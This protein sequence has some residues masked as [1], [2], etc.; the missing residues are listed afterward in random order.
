MKICDVVKNSVWYDPRVK[1]QLDS[2]V[3]S[4]IEV[5]AV[6]IEDPRAD[7]SEISK[8]PCRVA[9][10]KIDNKYYSSKRSFLKK[11][12][13]ELVGNKG[14]FKHL[15]NEKPDV[16]HAN[17]LNALIPAYKAAKKLKCKLIYDTHEIFLENPWIANNKLVRAVWAH[18]EKK[19][20]KR[21]DLVVCV[22]HA[23]ADYLAKEYNIPKPMVITNCISA[24]NNVSS[25]AI[26]KAQLKQVL[27]HGQFYGGRG[28]DIMI[29]AAPLLKDYPELQLVLRGYGSLEPQLR[30][31]AGELNAQNVTFA[32]PVR[33]YELIPEAAKAWVGLAITEPISINFELSVSNKLFEYAAA[34]LPV[35]MSNIP[36]HRY[37]NEKYNF[38][39]ILKENSPTEITEAVL[40]L[41]TDSDLYDTLRKNAAILS[42]EINWDT[43]FNK[44]LTFERSC[45]NSD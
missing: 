43:E 13:R 18:Y 1:K 36:E 25:E 34:G 30:Q 12:K 17:D 35:I 39:I 4:S 27:N 33:V 11:I 7:D 45:L 26:E 10:A 42:K 22:S 28:Y 19:I 31:R 3:K 2:Y 16:I 23:A 20:I 29:E 6:G 38:G 41:Y 21:V 44:L 15:I 24:S 32:P 37:L 9:L 5:V 40:K 8:L 14:I